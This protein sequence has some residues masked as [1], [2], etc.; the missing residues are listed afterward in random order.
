M[1]WAVIENITFLKFCLEV[2]MTATVE[3]TGNTH[4][5]SNGDTVWQKHQQPQKRTPRNLKKLGKV[6]EKWREVS[7]IQCTYKRFWSRSILIQEFRRKQCLSWILSSMIFLKE[8]RPK[9]EHSHVTTRRWLCPAAKFKLQ[10]ASCFR[11]NLPST[12]F[13]RE[14]K[15]S[16]N[17]PLHKNHPRCF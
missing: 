1:S 10:F 11:V 5:K 17:L 8:L 14:L 12:Q 3:R 7:R 4:F 2:V 15:L 13:Q 9:L 6:P 16:Q